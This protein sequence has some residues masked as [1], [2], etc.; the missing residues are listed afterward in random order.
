MSGQ[1]SFK[2]LPPKVAVTGAGGFIGSTVAAALHARG[3]RVRAHVGPDGYAGRALPEGVEI[4][5]ADIGDASAMRAIVS[6]CDAV[7][8]LAGPPSV[9]ASFERAAEYVAVHVGGTTVS[10][11]ACVDEGVRRFVYLS[12]ADVYGRPQTER[13]AEDHPLSARSPYAAAKIGAEQMVGAFAHARGLDTAILRPF[14]IYGPG[15]SRESLL[16]TILDQA[17]SQDEIV[18]ADLK[19]VR[20]YCYVD[21]LAEAVVVASSGSIASPLIVNVGTGIGTCVADLAC[22]VL[23]IV[24]ARARVAERTRDKRPGDSEIYRLVADTSKAQTALGWKPAT[25]LTSGLR[26]MIDAPA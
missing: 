7:I 22:I 26:M 12:S 2:S 9:R 21:D 15:M 13:V 25:S 14:S 6:G 5:H 8:H 4:V 20:D 19:P 1:T 24:G 11:Q 18:L 16:W 3:V 17:R 23:E 10:L